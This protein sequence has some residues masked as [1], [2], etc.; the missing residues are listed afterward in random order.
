MS[1]Q[2]T[3][4]GKDLLLRALANQT[5]IN[6]TKVQLG[7]G[8]DAGRSAS[9]LNNPLLDIGI[10]AIT[11]ETDFITL[12]TLFNNHAISAGFRA[13]EIGVWATDPDDETAIMLYAYGY[14]EEAEADYVPASSSRVLETSL[15]VIV[16]IGDA[17]NVTASISGSLVYATKEELEDHVEDHANPHGVTKAQIGL[18]NVPNVSTNDQAPT[19]SEYTQANSFSNFTDE[20]SVPELIGTNTV[21]RLDYLVSGETASRFMSKLQAAVKMLIRHLSNYANPHSVTFKQTGAAAAS[22]KH[23]AADITSGV[24]SIA[25]GGTGNANGTAVSAT[26]LATARTITVDLESSAGVGFDGT[27]PINP[28]VTG[29][30]P[31]SKGGTGLTSLAE[32]K[33]ALGSSRSAR[34]VIGTT[35]NGWTAKDCDYLCDGTDDQEE[36]NA[37]LATV[38]ALSGGGT[39]ILL[40]GNYRIS[41]N[42]NFACPSTELVGNGGVLITCIGNASVVC[43]ED[44]CLIHGIKITG[45]T[46]ENYMRLKLSSCDR[47]T[48]ENCH[49]PKAGIGVENCTNCIIRGNYVGES[50]GYIR[51]LQLIGGSGN[52]IADNN[53]S[54]G[55]YA[56]FASG[57]KRA[58]FTGNVCTLSNE[59]TFRGK[60]AVG[61]TI[62]GNIF[63]SNSGGVFENAVSLS[64]CRNVLMTGNHIAGVDDA[65]DTLLV[66]SSVTNFVLTGNTL[67]SDYSTIVGKITNCTNGLI[68]LN[69]VIG[70][71]GITSGFQAS[72]N[73]DV[74][75]SD[76]LVSVYD[77][78]KDA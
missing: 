49:F 42:V 21:M 70:K 75:I 14:T 51:G 66:M 4:G 16:Y 47:T 59:Y 67:L 15:D 33:T 25:R 12:K 73:T 77:A 7:N 27:A 6:F 10:S 31:P 26:K 40:D 69:N 60:S 65:D 64:S 9:A 45:S 54:G 41:G 13:T 11:I 76:N 57:T 39:V 20:N 8:S 34:F 24:L 55:F 35:R 22:H 19:Y 53:F 61:L 78:T 74:T 72:G 1:L 18:G 52:L 58:T 17:E 3:A 30:L 44:D 48:V 5:N 38:H 43:A 56:I 68:R 62:T 63:Y 50:N 36:I 28:G 23:S 71:A 32:L 29:V 37:A 2:L 46:S